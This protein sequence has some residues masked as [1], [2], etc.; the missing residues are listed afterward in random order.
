MPG[1]FD[2][3]EPQSLAEQ[4]YDED[5]Q[6]QSQRPAIRRPRPDQQEE[7]FEEQAPQQMETVSINTEEVEED[8]QEVV[9]HVDRRLRIAQYYRM[10]LDGSLFNDDTP[11]SKIVQNRIRKFVRDEIE[12]LFGMKVAPTAAA[13][14]LPFSAEEIDALKALAQATV[15]AKRRA[16][17]PKLNRIAQSPPAQQAAPVPALKPIQAPPQQARPVASPQPHPQVDRVDRAQKPRPP[18]PQQKPVPPAQPGVLQ[19]NVKPGDPSL[20]GDPRVPEDYRQDPTIRIK[21][22]HVYV[23]QRDPNGELLW[24]H[25]TGMARA[26]PL[27]KD[28]TP[29]AKPT[30]PIQPLPMPSIDMM[31]MLTEQR[32][33]TEAVENL[34]RIA[35]KLDPVFRGKIF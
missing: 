35:I 7:Y 3:D 30:G 18:Q 31:P 23:Q 27:L 4:G 32:A 13:V 34:E 1:Y 26:M 14:D 9:S 24:V 33:S 16:V 17:E 29:V 5:P 20:V 28:V 15:A 22:G 2:D 25:E 6:P 19:S 12:V 10:V 8:Y 21:N 11:E